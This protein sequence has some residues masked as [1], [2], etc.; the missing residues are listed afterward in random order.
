M[1]WIDKLERKFGR[2]GGIPNLTVYIIICYV[3][4]YLLTYMNPSLLSMMSLDVSKILQGQIWRLV[5]WVIYPISY[6]LRFLFCSFI[7]RSVP[8]LSVP[9]EASGIHCIYFPGFSLF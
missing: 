9:G 8:L 3:I 5:T 1:N 6:C 4:G 7:I 2:H